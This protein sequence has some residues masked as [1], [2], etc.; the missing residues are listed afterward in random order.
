MCRA[1]HQNKQQDRVKS[2]FA[3]SPQYRISRHLLQ[4]YLR[5]Q[6]SS[7][8]RIKKN[9]DYLETKLSPGQEN[10]AP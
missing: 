3:S 7:F 1:A 6:N 8:P 2:V 9:L 10:M 5:M 4:K